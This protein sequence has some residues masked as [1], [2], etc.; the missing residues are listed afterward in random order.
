MLENQSKQLDRI[1]KQVGETNGRVKSLEIWQAKIA[2][3][4]FGVRWVPSAVSAVV[5]G[6]LVSLFT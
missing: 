2:G 4:T 1:E 6:V 5:A 3:A